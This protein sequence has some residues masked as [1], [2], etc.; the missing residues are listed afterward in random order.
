MVDAKK[1]ELLTQVAAVAEDKHVW[2]VAIGGF[3]PIP[4]P[5]TGNLA[6]LG[7]VFGSLENVTMTLDLKD[8]VNLVA[9]GRCK[10]EKDAKQLHDMMRALIGFGRLSTPGDKPEMLRFFDGVKVDHANRTVKVNAEVPMNLVDYFLSVT[11]KGGP[12]A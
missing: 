12:K 2:V 11:G 7:R 6:N 8:G 10:E 3:A 1:K 9:T 5:E 4:L